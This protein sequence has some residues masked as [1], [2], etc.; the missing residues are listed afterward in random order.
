MACIVIMP[1]KQETEMKARYLHSAILLLFLVA[2]SS[3]ASFQVP[4]DYV[5]DGKVVYL[6]QNT[7]FDPIAYKPA[8]AD[9]YTFQ[10]DQ[11]AVSAE[12]PDFI[13]GANWDTLLRADF[14]ADSRLY[15]EVVAHFSYVL[16]LPVIK[17]LRAALDSAP[18][19]VTRALPPGKGD[20]VK[21]YSNGA[22][23]MYPGV[24]GAQITILDGG[25]YEIAFA[26]KGYFRHQA[27]GT[28][29]RVDGAGQVVFAYYPKQSKIIS[30]VDGTTYTAMP[31]SRM[32]KNANGSLTY[33]DTPEPQYRFTPPDDSA[34]PSY[35]FFTDEQKAVKEIMI[36]LKN[37]LRFDY[38]PKQTG[39]QQVGVL[40]TNGD[41]AIGIDSQFRKSHRRFNTV[42]RK[43]T[44]LLSFYLPEGIRLTNFAGSDPAYGVVKPA[45]PE[46]YR[47][48]AFGPFDVLST[49]KDETLVSRLRSDRLTA[50]EAG[51]RTLAGLSA[52]QRRTIIIPPDLDSYRKLYVS[53]PGEIL[54]WYPS[55]F[56]TND[57][58]VM[59]PISV[60]R[61][62]AP[63]GQDYF[64]DKE[65]Y[66]ILT[67]EYVH[68]LVGEN[69]GIESPVPVWLNEGLAVFVES[70]FSPEVKRYW[71]LTFEVSR[72][73][74]R[75]LDWD[76]V[77]TTGTGALRI[78]EARVHYAQSYALV[79][80][81][82]QK[83]GAAKVAE[84]VKSFRINPVDIDKVDLK[85][86]YKGHFK[87]VFGVSFSEAL[88]LL[89]PPAH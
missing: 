81:L 28:Y 57:I 11:A 22:V 80:A 65:F 83:Y 20:K 40:V 52:L 24:E 44:D 29:E 72:G 85:S 49:A 58:I 79:S 39:E 56:E 51:D 73:Q 17:E 12:K 35:V 77:T 86:S 6:T 70:H 43:T 45:W 59:W 32:L 13:H 27:D 9:P 19:E 48:R 54:N 82:E 4:N 8:S 33:V 64:F 15:R 36:Q 61:Y 55:G 30:T 7:G 21:D 41:Q 37:G 46:Q 31:G 14:Q 38:Y 63:A 3:C 42:E 88:K 1:A 10:P 47:T 5:P 68:V 69:T 78:G 75:L 74:K 87:Q 26:D 23:Y 53:R 76:L 18:I 25:Y 16:A 2:L 84:Y 34:A 67:H 62:S 66:E 89:D 50:V 60:P 71:D